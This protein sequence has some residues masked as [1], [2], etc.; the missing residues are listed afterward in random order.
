VVQKRFGIAFVIMLVLVAGAAVTAALVVLHSGVPGDITDHELTAIG[1][2]LGAGGFLLAATATVVA[3]VAYFSALPRPDIRL[4][5]AEMVA[6][7]SP[8]SGTFGLKITVANRGPIAAR[9]V[10]VRVTFSNWRWQFQS[11]NVPRA[12]QA[13]YSTNPFFEQV[14]WEGGVDAVVHPTW[15]Y[16]LPLLGN[17]VSNRSFGEF[18]VQNEAG[19]MVPDVIPKTIDFA[20]EIVA[21]RMRPRVV[22][23]SIRIS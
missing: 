19:E 3:V 17:L 5:S 11:P 6:Q 7:A 10:A 16:L 1:A 22:S 8:P 18:K 4:V 13:D 20:V 14:T 12:W 21:D 2:V 9:F 23:R 15:T